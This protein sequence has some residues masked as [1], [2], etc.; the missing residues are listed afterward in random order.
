MSDA[1]FLDGLPSSGVK[2][3]IDILQSPPSPLPFLVVALRFG[4]FANSL[5][6]LFPFLKC[7]LRCVIADPPSTYTDHPNT[8]LILINYCTFIVFNCLN[9]QFYIGLFLVLISSI[10]LSFQRT[11]TVSYSY[12]DPRTNDGR[13]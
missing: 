3:V 13:S 9:T 5:I 11:R 10:A 4:P 1:S 7:S 2:S 8:I 12:Y 6:C